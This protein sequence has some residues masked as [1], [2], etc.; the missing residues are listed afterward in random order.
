VSCALPPL[1]VRMT[2]SRMVRLFFKNILSDTGPRVWGRKK[3][4]PSSADEFGARVNPTTLV[5]FAKNT[6]VLF[7]PVFANPSDC[8]IQQQTNKQTNKQKNE[9]FKLNEQTKQIRCI[10]Q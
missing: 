10:L 1:P 7:S 2:V 4:G 8:A 9:K 5:A 6:A 3:M